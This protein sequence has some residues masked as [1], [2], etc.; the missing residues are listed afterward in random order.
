M[1]TP[2]FDATTGADAILAKWY[3]SIMGLRLRYGSHDDM[4]WNPADATTGRHIYAYFQKPG[5]PSIQ[6]QIVEPLNGTTTPYQFQV[7][8]VDVDDHFCDLFSILNTAVA[9]T[10]LAMDDA[11]D[12]DAVETEVWVSDASVLSVD[13]DLFIERETVRITNIAANILTVTR[14]MYGSTA[15]VHKSG[16]KVFDKPQFMNTREVLLYETRDGLVEADS[17]LIRGYLED[18]EEDQGV[19][20]LNCAGFLRRLNARIGETLASVPLDGNLWDGY[21]RGMLGADAVIPEPMYSDVI[22]I[23]SAAAFQDT[24]HVMIDDEIIKYVGHVHNAPELNNRDGLFITEDAANFAQHMWFWDY[25]NRGLFAE[26]IF[27]AAGFE[28]M[29]GH[30]D[31]QAVEY[32]KSIFHKGH[33]DGAEVK[34][35]IHSDKFTAGTGPAAVI[36]TLLTSTGVEDDNG[37]YDKLPEGWGAGIDEDLIDVTGIENVCKEPPLDGFDF[38]PFIIPEP[39]DMKDWLEENILRPC[40]LFFAETE[41]G[42]ITVKRLYDRNEAIVLTTPTVITE[43]ELVALPRLR[44]GKSPIGQIT[45]KMNWHPGTDEFMGII[46]CTLG[47]GQTYHEGTA[48]KFEI[49]CRALYDSRIAGGKGTWTSDSVGDMP[50]FLAHYLGLIWKNHALKP[51]PVVTFTVAYNR[52]IDVQVGQVVLLTSSSTPDLRAGDRGI[53][54]E[55]YQ[56]V[57]TRPMPRQS[58]VECVAWMIGANDANTRRLAPAAKVTGWIGGGQNRIE[59]EDS[60]FADGVEHTFDVEGFFVGDEVMLVDVRYL[61]LAGAGVPEEITV[62]EVTTGV[63]ACTIQLDALPADVPGAGDYVVPARYDNCPAAQQ[64]KWAWL[65]DGGH[66]I[67]AANLAA[68]KRSR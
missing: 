30:Q 9:T 57:E 32:K 10:Y 44:P 54:G 3:I 40:H 11:I 24:G 13:S 51:L 12:L 17:I 52:L 49:E 67:G 66:E 7:R 1:S 19:W 22:S 65:A 21:P 8:L 23:G 47:K 35:I 50:D 56:I 6:P 48:R 58:T 4:A 46:N 60:Y 41:D 20:T 37:D 43:D 53:S 2:A 42:T 63:G 14:G 5:I 27:G 59:C 68:H 26:E 31:H 18:Y 34:E 16:I 39:T 64:V 55:Y 33:L 45:M 29:H 15:T 28:T 36:L 38:A 62:L 25:G 61:P